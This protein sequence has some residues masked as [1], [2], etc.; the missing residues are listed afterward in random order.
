MIAFAAEYRIS[1]LFL[2]RP[3]QRLY[4]E[5]DFILRYTAAKKWCPNTFATTK[6]LFKKIYIFFQIGHLKKIVGDRPRPPHEKGP[7]PKKI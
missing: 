6:I 4:T 1:V 2:G 3:T 5:L 7:V